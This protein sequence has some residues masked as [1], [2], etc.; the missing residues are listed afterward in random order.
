MKIAIVNQSTSVNNTDFYCMVAGARAQISNEFSWA[1]GT[2]RGPAELTIYSDIENVPDGYWTVTIVDDP[3]QVSYFGYHVNNS[4]VSQSFVF[5]DTIIG[6]GCPV[7]YDAGDPTFFTVSSLLCHEI[8]EMIIDPCINEWWDGPGLTLSGNVYPIVS[9]AAEVCDPVYFDVYTKTISGDIGLP[10]PLSSPVNVNVCNFIY[11]AWKDVYAD[12]SAQF[13]QMN[14]L[15]APFS[16]DY[17]GYMLVRNAAYTT[18][19][20]VYGARFPLNFREFTMKHSRAT[21]RKNHVPRTKNRPANGL[22]RN[23]P[24]PFDKP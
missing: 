13:D 23:I 14:V 19:E 9:Y 6:Y 20:Y 21:S 15:S 4:P 11:P 24:N 17:G 18:E 1:W 10:S 12:P 7:L 3:E 8:L 2:E 5:A 16:M 22:A